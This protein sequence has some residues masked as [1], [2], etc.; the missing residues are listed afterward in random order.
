MNRKHGFTLIEAM[1]VICLIALMATLGIMQL[2]F[3]DAT[4]THAEVDKFAV[5]C[6]YL[7]QKAIAT[8]TE[9]VLVFDEQH[10]EYRCDTMHEV[11]SQRIS[12]GSLPNVLGPPGS[13]SHKIEKAITF[14]QCEIHFYPTGIIS[15]GTVYFVDKKKQYMYALSNA[16][17]QFSYLRLY[18]YDGKWKLID[19]NF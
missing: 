2:S 13:P 5:V 18:R 8:N 1:V 3:L 19:T 17:S 11:L 10:N 15:S 14:P 16:V 4:I 7:Q 6:S 9:L 12:F